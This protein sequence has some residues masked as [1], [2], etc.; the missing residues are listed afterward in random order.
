MEY[1]MEGYRTI[2]MLQLRY[3]FMLASSVLSVVSA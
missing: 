1:G 3:N 2:A